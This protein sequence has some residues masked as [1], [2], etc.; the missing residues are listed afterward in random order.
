MPQSILS[1]TVIATG[2]RLLNALLGIVTIKLL[3]NLLGQVGF[4]DYTLLLSYGALVQLVADFG[5]YLTLTRE[6]AQ[7]PEQEQHFVS[8]ILSLRLT[9]LLIAFVVGGLLAGFIPSLARLDVLWWVVALALV[10]QSLSQLLMGIYQKYGVVW[11][12]LVGDLS[13]RLFQIVGFVL[14]AQWDGTLYHVLLVF[15]G[16]TLLAF[17]LHRRLLPIRPA[18][19]LVFIWPVWKQLLRV[20][21]PLGAM[22]VLNAIYFRI[23][24]LILSLFRPVAEVG[25]YGLAYRVIENG[26]FFPA[27][28]G[29]LLLPRLS[30]ALHKH[31]LVQVRQLFREGLQLLL[32][33]ATFIVVL[34]VV[35]PD[36]VVLFFANESFIAAAGYLRIL[37]LALAVMFVGNLFGFTL[38]ALR[39]QKA[40]V[41]LYG[42]LVAFNLLG[43]LLLVPRWGA[44]AAAWTT[45]ATEVIAMTIA[46][47]LVYRAIHFRISWSFLVRVLA[48][49]AVTVLLLLYLP[50]TF[51][52]WGQLLLGAV[53]YSGTSLLLGTLRRRQL[54]LLTT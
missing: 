20:S 30:S 22:L 17:W 50:A 12:V 35:I 31:D 54:I 32:L 7:H 4:G 40:L 15:L 19:R 53:V 3:T 44:T 5:L 37:S 10:F 43:N 39:K 1:N 28:F 21:W 11:R 26:L 2:G 47:W 38:V 9:L 33:A 14:I 29:G 48:A 52:V 45:V 51:P 18:A 49:G 13:G 34:L 16:S 24:I 41:L 36:S 27:M 8:H 25:D 46:G 23:D 42:A 6:I